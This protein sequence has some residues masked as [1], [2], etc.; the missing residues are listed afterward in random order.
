M[1]Q[2]DWCRHYQNH[3]RNLYIIFQQACEAHSVNW[4]RRISFDTFCEF[5]YNNSAKELDPWV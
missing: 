2:Q 3:L 1:N 4:H 5:I